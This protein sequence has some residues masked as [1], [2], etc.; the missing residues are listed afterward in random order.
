MKFCLGSQ[1]TVGF[2]M[3]LLV[4]ILLCSSIIYAQKE[5]EIVKKLRVALRDDVLDVPEPSFVGKGTISMANIN[6]NGI[7]YYHKPNTRMDLTFQGATFIRFDNDTVQWEYNPFDNQHTIKK[8]DPLE[9]QEM[10]KKEKAIDFASKELLNYKSLKN[11]LTFK[12]EQMVDTIDTYVLELTVKNADL[13]PIT[14]YIAKRTNLVYKCE[15]GSEAR[16]F[17]NYKLFGNYI[18][19]TS[20]VYKDG[21]TNMV[22]KFDEITIGKPIPDSLFVVPAE[23]YASTKKFDLKIAALLEG[24]DSLFTSSQYD[25]AITQYTEVLKLDPNNFKALNGRGLSKINQG[26]QYEAIADLNMAIEINPSGANALNNRGLAKFY[27]G[28]NNGALEDYTEAIQ[29]D[30]TLVS[31]YKNR[32]LLQLRSGKYEEARDDFSKAVRLLPTDGDAY[33]KYGV[34][35]AQLSRHEEALESYHKAIELNVVTDE[36][37]NYRGVSEFKLEKYQEAAISFSTAIKKNEGNL[38][39]LENLGNALYYSG[40][41]KKALVE[42]EGYLKK[43]AKNDEIINMVGLCKYQDE[44]YKGAIKDFSK[45]IELNG[46]SAIYYDNRASAKEQIEDYEG[47]IIDYTESISR[48]PTDAST[49]Y[50]R[51][52]IKILSSKKLEGCMDLGTAKDMKYGAATDA[53]MKHCN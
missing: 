20:M 8:R 52:L 23:A 47:A 3:T 16:W 34:A 26:K 35:V 45:A 28:D 33:L 18:Y 42:F 49:F 24:A 41:F 6:F 22:L 13:L 5:A 43:D 2:R 46:K 39:Y 17:A 25:A 48:N 40:D 30:T 11:Q 27:L 37:Y 7:L 38:Q 32:G 14:F 53:I 36:V 51:G 12:G 50:K 4:L 10:L 29:L 15:I 9:Y 19:P 31:V 1:R 21:D 44:D